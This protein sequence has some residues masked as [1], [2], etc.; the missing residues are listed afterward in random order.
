MNM[1]IKWDFQICISVPLNKDFSNKFFRIRIRKL[2]LCILCFDLACNSPIHGVTKYSSRASSW[3]INVVLQLKPCCYNINSL[4]KFNNLCKDQTIQTA[5]NM[6]FSIKN[7]SSKCNQIRR[8]LRIWLHL[9]KKYLME[10]FTFCIVKTIVC[11][12]WLF[13]Q[14]FQIMLNLT[15][16]P[17]K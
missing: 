5:Q 4:Q 14:L 3:T 12:Q 6:K 8:K 2:C 13:S 9:L 15:G 10:N 16:W 1:N 11:K 7:F 17:Y